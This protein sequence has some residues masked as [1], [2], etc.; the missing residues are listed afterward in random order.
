MIPTK[1]MT[2]HVPITVQEI[3]EDVHEAV[4]IGITMVHIHARDE[5]TGEPTY[6]AEVYGD[7]IAGI[8]KFCDD[9]VICVSLSGRTFKEFEKRAAPLELTGDVKPDMGSLTLSSVNFNREA[10]VSSPEMIQQLAEE[11]QLR[12]ILPELEAFDTGMINY[13]KYLEKRGLLEAPHYFNLIL[14][15]TACAQADLLH[16]GVMIR[17]LPSNSVWSLGGVG[18]CQL[19]V[20]SIAVAADGGVRV[21]IEDDVWYD[22]ARTR[23]ARNADLVRRMHRLAEANE[24]KVMTPAELRKLLNLQ[25]GNGEYGRQ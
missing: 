8:R 6:K 25:G 4:D 5:K 18:D 23:L 1:K 14:G 13:A 3:V 15:N 24:R 9:L 16:A 10:S 2:P 12:G 7:I 21:G 22:P 20:N 19:M 11:M 17:D